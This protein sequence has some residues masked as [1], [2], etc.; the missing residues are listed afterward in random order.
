MI[1][2]SGIKESY[3]GKEVRKSPWEWELNIMPEW[4]GGSNEQQQKIPG[5]ESCMGKSK[6]KVCNNIWMF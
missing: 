2:H 1:K 6:Y 4:W 3:F 5:R